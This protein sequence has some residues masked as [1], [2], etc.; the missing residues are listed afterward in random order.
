LHPTTQS[1]SGGNQSGRPA[2]Q[3]GHLSADT[4][5]DGKPLRTTPRSIFARGE[6][7]FGGER[8]PS[9]SVALPDRP[10]DVEVPLPT[11]PQQA[12]L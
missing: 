5:L 6:G 10:P 4:D 8:G 2:C 11:L 9:T 7:G 12:V 1:N 3:T